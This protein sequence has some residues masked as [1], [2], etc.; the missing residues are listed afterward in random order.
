MACGIALAATSCGRAVIG[1]ADLRMR[2]TVAPAV[3]R[4]FR[5]AACECRRRV[6]STAPSEVASM[7]TLSWVLLMLT[8]FRALRSLAVVAN[9]VDLSMLICQICMWPQLLG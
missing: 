7:A 1:A 2:S 3:A 9:A 6:V 4:R 8:R 5:S